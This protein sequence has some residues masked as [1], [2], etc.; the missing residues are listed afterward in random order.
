MLPPKHLWIQPLLCTSLPSL[1]PLSHHHL[2]PS[3]FWTGLPISSLG[4]FNPLPNV[5]LQGSFYHANQSIMALQI[6]GWP[7]SSSQ[8]TSKL[9]IWSKAPPDLASAHL[10]CLTFYLFTS[11]LTLQPCSAFRTLNIL[12]SPLLTVQVQ[13]R[14]HFLLEAFQNLPS[15]D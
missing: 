6:L 10:S 14:Y 9:L 2:S 12:C 5:L 7:L 3:G 13:V 15:L 4:P 1:S 11:H 8:V